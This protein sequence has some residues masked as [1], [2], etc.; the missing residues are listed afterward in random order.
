LRP[1]LS[2]VTAV[3]VMSRVMSVPA[4]VMNA[5][6]PSMR[7]TPSASVARVRVAPA[8]VPP[9]GSVRPKAASASPLVSC[10]S[11]SLRCSSVPKRKTGIAP[12]E[13]PASRVIATDESTRAS[14][15]IA[16]QSAK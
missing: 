16:R 8:S 15:S 7:H 2:P 3:T 4:L 6:V 14:S 5:F 9:S 13:T 11:H 1:P 12:S 10:G